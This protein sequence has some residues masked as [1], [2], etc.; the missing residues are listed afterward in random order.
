VGKDFTV[1]IT[2]PERAKFFEEVFGRTT[3]NVKSPI[4]ELAAL[5]GHPR[6]RVFKLDLDLITPEER[7]RLILHLAGRF[8]V[9]VEEVRTDLDQEGVPILDKHCYVAVANPMKWFS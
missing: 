3:V 2:D 5:P 8:N 6:A 4:P 9:P 1:T 7:E